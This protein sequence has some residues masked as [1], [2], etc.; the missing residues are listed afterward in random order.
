MAAAFAVALLLS[1]TNQASAF[2]TTTFGGLRSHSPSTSLAAST[3]DKTDTTSTTP[4]ETT[5]KDDSRSFTDRVQSSG[6]TAAAAAA[7]A[8]VN[9]AV[10]MKSLEAPDLAKS[11]ISIDRNATESGLTDEEGLPLVYDKDLIE[12]YWR[13]QRG[14]LNKRWGTFVGKAVPFITKLTTLFIRDGKIDDSEIP[15]L[16]RRARI[17]LQDLGPTFIKLGQVMSVRPDV[18]PQASLDELALLQDSVVPFDTEVAVQVIEEELNAPLGQYFTSISEEP[19]AAASLAQVYMAT[20]NDGN[21]TR[22]AVK[23]Q[24]PDVLGTVSK[25][26]YVLRRAA[27]VWQ[28]LIERFAP[29]Q[30]TNYVA[31]LNEWAIGFYTELDFVN[32]AANQRKLRNL[33]QSRNVTQVVVPQVYDELCTRRL[34]VSEWVDGTKLSQCSEEEV[35]EVTTDAQEAFLHQLFS[36]GFFHADPHPGNL[37]YLDEPTPEGARVALIDCGLMATIDETDRDN[38]IS[39]LIHL[40]N[41]DYP[42]LVDDFINLKILPEDT[43]R[44]AVIPLMDKALSPYVKGGGA[45]SYADEVRKIYGMEDDAT[46]QGQVGGFQAMTQDALTVLND[47]PF[48]I[49]PYFALLGRAIVT[50]EGVALSGDPSFALIRSSYPFVARKLLGDNEDRPG[51]Q[52]ALQEV[53]YSNDSEGSS[54]L[55]LTRLLALLNNAATGTV[56]SQAGSSSAFVDLDT[57]PED[58][59]SLKDG[60]KY[61]LS[62]NAASLRKLLE[63]E[64]DIVVDLLSRQIFRRA[65]SE[66][67]VAITPPRPPS[68]PFVGDVFP[69]PP[70]IDE[71]PLPLLL[72]GL[73]GK[74]PMN[75][76]PSV[77]L[78]T[79]KEFTDKVAPKL[80]QDEDIY[81]IGLAEGASEFFGDDIGNLIK[82]ERVLSPQSIQILLDAVRSG[83]LGRR[84]LASS[85]AANAVINFVSNAINASAQ[86]R[87]Q[88]TASASSNPENDLFAA[89]DELNENDRE[90]LDEIVREVTARSIE[91]AANRL[92]SVERIL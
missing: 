72:P 74:D 61:L 3:L 32:E 68:I 70:P 24:R 54:G 56:A 26:L 83:V 25:D 13:N 28:G 90:T 66:A 6:M 85:D 5:P 77:G 35:K 37:L 27:E 22:V 80:N 45:Q 43:N 84:D 81:A 53:L 46:M 58:G 71:V 38:M 39:A 31:L 41:K 87:G 52:K 86:R 44:A 65:M 75:R 55:K 67:M 50:L 73:N 30:K 36:F 19:V 64:M 16:S 11:Y 51:L 49:P 34:L 78:M 88:S 79:L 57:I 40:A 15:E 62:S 7:T 91:R 92:A 10:A 48:Q 2:S 82:G 76:R 14:A 17:E 69:K 20:L 8:A 29:Q 33:L 4:P 21:N 12:N 9:A 60:L 59:L 89:I 63:S 42:A 23:V 47:I 18:L 1:S